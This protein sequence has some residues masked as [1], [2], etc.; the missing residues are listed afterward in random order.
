MFIKF[1]KLSLKCVGIAS[2]QTSPVPIIA[3]TEFIKLW[4]MGK[5]NMAAH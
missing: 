2:E 4:E 1:I 3:T 5:L